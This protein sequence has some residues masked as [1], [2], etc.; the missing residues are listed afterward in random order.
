MKEKIKY[1]IPIL[2]IIIFMISIV[3]K[4]FQND[5]FFTIAI[6]K[7]I[8]ENG[9]Q[10]EEK[11]VWH[12]GLEFTNS[13]WLFDILI[14]IIYDMYNFLG[15]YIFVIIFAI[16]QAILYYVMLYH[17]TKNKL[18]SF[19]FTL[20]TMHESTYEF[21]AR[22]QIISFTLFLL[23][24]YSLEKFMQNNKKI[25]FIILCCIS[26]LL[27]N[28]HASVFPMYFIFYLPYIVENIISRLKLKYDNNSKILISRKNNIKYL[29]ILI[30]IGFILGF[31]TP[32][33]VKP[34][35][36]MFKATTEVAT[37]LI[38]ELQPLDIT[39]SIYFVFMII[40]TLAII[41][42]TKTEVRITDCF[43]I[44]GFT[45]MS[46]NTFRCI[47]F[48]YLISTICVIRIINDCLIDYNINT[49]CINLKL[50]KFIELFFVVLLL[51]Y[52]CKNFTNK[53][54][55][56]YI[57]T[58][59]YPVDAT[60]YIINN[61]DISSMKIFNHFNFGS[62]LEFRGIPVFI[63]SRSGI[64]T[65]EFN[66]GVTILA[67]YINV[68]NG[69]ISYKKLFKDYEIT[70]ALLYNNEII[71]IY[72]QDDEEWELLYQDDNFSLYEKK[73]KTN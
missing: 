68:H 38:M 71:N 66:E 30:I 31:C 65:P 73:E 9:V 19:I 35:T 45:L 4:S 34:Y 55:Q 41:A 60:N 22:A 70:H 33:G 63:D 28:I 21:T 56:D 17:I 67:D 42:F 10:K 6:G 5:T 49:K 13:R 43:F 20:I 26:F 46:L 25:Y 54:N 7:D 14:T 51:S 59:D 36:D 11:L 37:S 39:D 62:Y 69:V 58:R 52:C 8:L 57:D 64:Y 3:P 44:L 40:I 24:F 61:I 12:E 18:L 50:R 47:Y 16:I 1:L 29:I 53:L 2:L 27:A 15:I 32:P 72:I 23:E 48:F